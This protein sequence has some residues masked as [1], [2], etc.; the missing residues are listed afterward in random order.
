M[1]ALYWWPFRVE[2]NAASLKQ[3]VAEHTAPADSVAFRVEINA[4]SL[5][6]RQTRPATGDYEPFRVEINAASLKR[7]LERQVPALKLAFPR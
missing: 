1:I 5:K 6:R 7:V 2:I 4:A 3:R